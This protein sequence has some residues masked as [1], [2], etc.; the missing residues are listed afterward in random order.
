MHIGGVTEYIVPFSM[1][2]YN[3]IWKLDIVITVC[4]QKQTEKKQNA[5]RN[6]NFFY[7]PLI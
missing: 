7:N 6:K 4:I 3:S 1:F 5:N 2:K